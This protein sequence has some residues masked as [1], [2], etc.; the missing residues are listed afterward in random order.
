[1]LGLPY[2]THRSLIEPLTGEDHIKL[3][4]IRRFLGFM[5]KIRKSGKL[6]LRMLQNEAIS[7]VRSVTGSNYRNIMFLVGQTS[8]ED[9]KI[10]DIKNLTYN[11]LD[12][13]DVWKVAA[14]KEVVNA[15]FGVL[16]VPGFELD[17]LEE[18]LDHLCTA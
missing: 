10:E 2:A 12:K 16:E 7:D 1:M 3:V 4:L 15:K 6:A 18:I 11:E 17:E 13:D 8:V 9:I 14:I 5:E